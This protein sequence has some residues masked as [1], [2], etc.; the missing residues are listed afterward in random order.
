MLL[1]IVSV[2]L[3]DLEK[4]LP[5]VLLLTLTQ[6]SIRTLL[7]NKTIESQLLMHAVHLITT[8]KLFLMLKIG[9]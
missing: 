3:L 9:N 2:M 4:L 6:I 1:L 7:L 5:T 8:L